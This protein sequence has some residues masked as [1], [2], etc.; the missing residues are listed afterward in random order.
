MLP[1]PAPLEVI[2][3]GNPLEQRLVGTIALV[4]QGAGDDRKLGQVAHLEQ[5]VAGVR[6]KR[7]ERIRAQH[8]HDHRTVAP[9]GL[10]CQPTMVATWKG[11]IALLHEGR[12]LV[13]EVVHVAPGARRVEELRTAER[14]PGID[15]HHDRIGALAGGEHRVEPFDHR[16][17]ER[18]PAQPGVDLAAVALDQEHDGHAIARVADARRLV[19]VQRSPRRVAER[20]IGEQL[21]FDDQLVQRAGQRPLPR[22]PRQALDL[23]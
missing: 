7:S 3:R 17:L 18:L 9:G 13:A 22:P 16:R 15:E 21:R 6:G 19:H 5:R 1:P 23:A 14:G 4:S 12:H 8:R 11:R 20:V 10:T 2:R